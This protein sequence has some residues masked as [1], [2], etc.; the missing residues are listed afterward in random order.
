MPAV[1]G[2]TTLARNKA[3]G[4]VR[5]HPDQQPTDMAPR[6]SQQRRCIF[7]TQLAAHHPK[8]RVVPR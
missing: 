5:A 3:F 2:L 1:A 6:Q 4:T 8:Q 7:N